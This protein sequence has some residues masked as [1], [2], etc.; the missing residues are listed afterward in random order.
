M[1]STGV[2]AFNNAKAEEAKKEAPCYSNKRYYIT[3][4][5]PKNCLNSVLDISFDSSGKSN[6][7]TIFTCNFLRQK[8]SQNQYG[9]WLDC[10]KDGK[11]DVIFKLTFSDCEGNTCFKCKGTYIRKIGDTVVRSCK[12]TGY[13]IECVSRPEKKINL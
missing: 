8:S 2:I 5:C 10:D 6:L 7:D 12:L 1:F 11:A 4:D 3:V 13:V 9:A